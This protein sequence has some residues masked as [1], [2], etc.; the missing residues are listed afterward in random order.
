MIFGSGLKTFRIE[1]HKREFSLLPG[2]FGGGNHPHQ[3]HFELLSELGIIGYLLII[4]NLLLIL[5]KQKNIKGDFLKITGF[6]FVIASLI[7]ILPS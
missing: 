3:L 5:I 2:G 1:S 6:L 4:S 7:P